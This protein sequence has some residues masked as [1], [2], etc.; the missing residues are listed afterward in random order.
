MGGW[1]GRRLEKGDEINFG[2]SRMYYA[3]LLNRDKDLQPLSWK[4]CT[5]KLYD[6]PNDMLFLPGPEWDQLHGIS[7]NDF[8]HESFTI[9]SLS[10]RMG[11]FRTSKGCHKETGWSLITGLKSAPVIEINAF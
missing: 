9:Q 5:T 1:Q 11:F 6:Q 3:G 10:D 7:R 2:E 8:Q 4:A